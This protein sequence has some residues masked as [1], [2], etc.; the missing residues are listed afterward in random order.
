MTIQR[1]NTLPPANATLPASLRAA[2]SAVKMTALQVLSC[3]TILR[4]QITKKHRAAIH[5]LVPKNTLKEADGT[6]FH[7]TRK[8]ASGLKLFLTNAVTQE[9]KKRNSMK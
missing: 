6:V 4:T 2:A 5:L 1:L 3:M 9:V 8:T 7:A